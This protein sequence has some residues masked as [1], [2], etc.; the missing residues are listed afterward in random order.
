M[1]LLS[2]Q[3]VL[4]VKRAM[5]SNAFGQTGATMYNVQHNTSRDH[6]PTVSV[7]PCTKPKFAP[8]LT[9]ILLC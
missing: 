9:T 8:A 6:P 7:L 2:M 3:S 1:V 4:F 5:F